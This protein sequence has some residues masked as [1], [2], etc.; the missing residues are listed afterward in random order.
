LR[1]SDHHLTTVSLLPRL[2][3]Q[4]QNRVDGH[5]RLVVLNEATGMLS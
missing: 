2:L 4:A 1:Y 3:H 5:L